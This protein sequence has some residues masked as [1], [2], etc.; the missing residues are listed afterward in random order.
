MVNTCTCLLAAILVFSILGYMAHIQV[1][2][3]PD[4]QRPLQLVL[5][6]NHV[7][8]VLSMRRPSFAHACGA[9]S[10]MHVHAQRMP[11][12]Y[13]KNSRRPGCCSYGLYSTTKDWPKLHTKTFRL[14]S[15]YSFF[16]FNI[17]CHSD[18]LSVFPCWSYRATT[19]LPPPPKYLSMEILIKN[20]PPLL[21]V[22]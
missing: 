14:C 6:G 12:T 15:R 19:P 4:K 16:V 2:H 22:Q 9:R 13:R 11:R 18:Y 8:N 3:H 20:T 21:R 7:S 1:P 5:W 17:Q 10:P